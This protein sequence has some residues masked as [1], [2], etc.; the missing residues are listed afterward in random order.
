MATLIK[1][2]HHR[3]RD[4]CPRGTCSYKKGEVKPNFYY[5]WTY[6]TSRYQKRSKALTEKSFYMKKICGIGYFT[7]YHAKHVAV[8]M[9]GVDVLAYIHIIKGRNLIKQGITSL[10][11]NRRLNCIDYK[12]KLVRLR[13]WYFPEEYRVTIHRKG[14]F[15][16]QLAAA[17]RRYGRKGFNQRYKKFFIASRLGISRLTVSRNLWAV[18]KK[19]LEQDP[20]KVAKADLEILAKNLENYRL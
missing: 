8:K 12:G 11:I 5:I 9:Y 15:A 14:L 2:K 6:W 17:W 20:D 7:R 16:K 1:K 19:L 18:R 13:R 4:E 10:P 3:S